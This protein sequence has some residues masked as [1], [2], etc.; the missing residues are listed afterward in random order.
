MFSLPLQS[1]SKKT[2]LYKLASMKPHLIFFHLPQLLGH[3]SPFFLWIL[4]N[5]PPLPWSSALSPGIPAKYSLITL[6]L[7]CKAHSF[8]RLKPPSLNRLLQTFPS[9]ALY[10]VVPF[11]Q[12]PVR[13]STWTSCSKLK[14]FSLLTN[15]HSLT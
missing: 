12:L 8:S 1:F 11:F 3:F 9:L 14:S 6:S 15:W 2:D 7:P 13:L 10:T 4:L 5:K